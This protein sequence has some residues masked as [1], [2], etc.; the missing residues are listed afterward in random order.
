MP[1]APRIPARYSDSPQQLRN[2]FL[3]TT[4]MPINEAVAPSTSPL[5]FPHFADSGGYTTQFILFSGVR[6]N[7]FR[8]RCNCS[9][10]P[11]R[12]ESVDANDKN[13]VRCNPWVRFRNGTDGKN[14]SATITRGKRRSILA[15]ALDGFCFVGVFISTHILSP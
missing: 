12:R 11:D 5:F 7:R 1:L 15:I 14:F 9:R 2:D 10:S 3:I 6:V 13:P 8:D 4:T